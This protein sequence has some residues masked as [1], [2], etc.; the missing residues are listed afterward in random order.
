MGINGGFIIGYIKSS[1]LAKTHEFE[2]SARDSVTK[3]L[4]S[5]LALLVPCFPS[6]ASRPGV[7]LLLSCG[8][9]QLNGRFCES[10]ALYSVFNFNLTCKQHSVFWNP[11]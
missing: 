1:C 3:L 11:Q 2:N 9:K 5:R 8:M 4:F 6:S 7:I 10:F